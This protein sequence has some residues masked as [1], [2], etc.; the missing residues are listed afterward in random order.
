MSHSVPTSPAVSRSAKFPPLT[1]QRQSCHQQRTLS[2]YRSP[3]TPSNSPYTP[4]SLRSLNSNGSST[5]TT[6][7]NSGYSARKRLTFS[8]SP[9][10]VQSANASK[11]K[12]LADVAENW[13]S[14]TGSA[15]NKAG[16]ANQDDSSYVLDDRKSIY[17]PCCCA[18]VHNL[19]I[20]PV[21]YPFLKLLMNRAFY[22][23]KV[24]RRHLAIT[25][26]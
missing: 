25:V 9:E 18:Y 13:R 23:T 14:G 2:L 15:E 8:G 12:S 6:P 17:A 1:P 20:Q 24:S 3:V 5:L 7:D 19:R 22:L 26:Y 4:I 21:T 11:D 10:V 16:Y